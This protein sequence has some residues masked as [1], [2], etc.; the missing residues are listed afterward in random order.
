MASH[1][2]RLGVLGGGKRPSQDLCD[3]ELFQGLCTTQL[4]EGS[5]NAHALDPHREVSKKGDSGSVSQGTRHVP[6]SSREDLYF[7][8]FSTL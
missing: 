3:G 2:Q 1:R 8:Y 4:H 5:S 6:G 7:Y